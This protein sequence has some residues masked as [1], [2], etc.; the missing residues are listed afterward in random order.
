M[1]KKVVISVLI[2][3]VGV[4]SYQLLNSKNSSRPGQVGARPATTTQAQPTPAPPGARSENNVQGQQPNAV[5]RE[6]KPTTE[7]K[8]NAQSN[9]SDAPKAGSDQAKTDSSAPPAPSEQAP[10][11]RRGGMGFNGG[12][13]ARQGTTSVEDRK[14]HV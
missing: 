5:N 2:L 8:P 13:L 3:A 4:L 10:P 9:A 1:I 11:Q 7:N 12:A 14:R 6:Q